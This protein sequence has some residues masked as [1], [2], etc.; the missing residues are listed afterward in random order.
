LFY[1]ALRTDRTAN[2]HYYDRF[3]CKIPFLNGGLFDPPNNFDWVNVDLLLPNELF[4]NKNRTK[5]GDIGD[6]ILDTFDRYNFTVNEEE[7]L[8]KD[9]ALDPEL[10]GKI[11]EKLNAIREDN[12]G[13]YIK[14]L[15]SGKKGEV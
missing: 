7:N 8:E 4:S 2:E 10:L 3:K 11:Y 15:K 6:G 1:E 12:F 5:E 9:V 13:E 14:V